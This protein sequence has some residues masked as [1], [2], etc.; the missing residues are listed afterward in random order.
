MEHSNFLNR[1]SNSTQHAA[2]CEFIASDTAKNIHLKGLNGSS[3]AMAF[4]AAFKQNQSVFVVLNDREE[5]AYFFDDISLFNNQEHVLFFPSSFKRQTKYGKISQEN[6]L[7]RT[8][9]LNRINQQRK[10]IVISYPEAL[11]EKV[12]PVN[13]LKNNTFQINIGDKLS[14]EFINDVLHEYG[15]ERTDFVFEPGHYSVRGSIIDIFSFAHEEPFR[16]DFFG[17]E[18]ETIRSFDIETQLSIKKF[19]SISVVP[20]L[21]T[22]LTNEQ[23]VGLLDFIPNTYLLAFSN[24]NFTIDQIDKAFIDLT[25]QENNDQPFDENM[26]CKGTEFKNHISIFKCIEFGNQ[27]T[28]SNASTI[29]YNTAPQPQFNKNFDL[30][31]KNLRE[32]TQNDY[33][34]FILSNN[35]QQIERLEAIFSDRELNVK[36]T[37]MPFTLHQGF[38]DRDLKIA[39]YTDHQI[40]ERYHR[41]RLQTANKSKES[42]TLKELNKL[43]AGD[44]VVH[45]DHGIGKF[46]GLVKTEINGK[47]QEAIR[48]VYKD[49]DSLLVSIH[50]LH[51]ISKYKGKEGSEPNL[52]KLGTGAWQKMKSKAKS[53]VKDIA[54]E[55]IALYA[56][57]L[58]EKGFAFSHDTYLQQE[59]EASFMYEDTPDQY[60]ATKA[61][62]HDMEKMMPMDRLV[63]GDVG[64]GKTEVAIRAAFKAVADSK[65]VAVLVPTTILAFQHYKTFSERLK[66][67]PAKIGYVSRLRK[68]N[69][70][71]DTLTQLK[72]GEIDIVIGTH[73]LVGKDVKFKDLGLL[74]VDEEQKFGVSVKEKLKQFKINVDTL[75]LTATPIPRTLQFSLMGARDLSVI[76]TPP[77]NRYPIVTELHGFNENVIREAIEYEIDRGGQVFFIHNRVQNIYEVSDFIRKICPKARITVGH[78]QMDGPVL[79]KTM[80]DFI[81]GKF[82]ILIATTIIESGLDIPNANTIIINNAQNFGLSDLHQ[83]RGRVGRSNK[84]AFC[85]LLAPPLST[86]SGE[87][88]RRLKAIEEFSELG[89]GFNIAMRDLDIRGAGNLLGAEQS[90]F[91]ADIGYE[92]YHRILNEAV[93]ELKHEEFK[94]LFEQ[95]EKEKSGNAFMQLKFLNDCNIETD[96][97]MRFPESY[98]N[99]TSERMSLYRELDNIEDEE[100]LQ[101]FANSLTDRFGPVPEQANELIAVVRLRWIAIQ[102]GIERIVMKAGKMNCYFIADQNSPFFQSNSFTSI[103]NWVQNNHKKC[104]ITEH[105]NKLSLSFE[106]VTKVE[107]AIT[108]L[109]EILQN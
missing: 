25:N 102:L 48:L 6:I 40:F 4:A 72:S 83:L 49:N 62:K 22:G 30:V 65:Q 16:I 54:K 53:K 66:D 86:L 27:T 15:F 106:R 96:M 82:D 23:R 9:V 18:V 63:C 91:I 24:L 57:R 34:N 88:R 28:L 51:R 98:I 37:P 10:C 41:Y 58:K 92:T 90:G 39:V 89:S 99:S 103:L 59:L 101:K 60:K 76:Q 45:I 87:A 17:D 3:A 32:N 14:I 79:E 85:Y 81:E 109:S 77:P 100:N 47:I 2:F 73:R 11:T 93:E 42:I 70:I 69:E 74:I 108:L 67:F 26:L 46:A 19:D 43:H 44:Y 35:P 94:D 61:V 13:I 52:N 8:E 38:S 5:A 64:F 71:K 31:A 29:N 50:S 104:K 1:F 80:L 7:Q 95:Q 105:K 84:K 55:L 97:E 20:N 75:T 107:K 12:V 78:G 33:Q 21:Q 36:F 56:E 68:S